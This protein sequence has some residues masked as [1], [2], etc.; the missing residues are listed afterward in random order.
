MEENTKKKD[1]KEKNIKKEIVGFIKTIVIAIICGVIINSTIIASAHVIS[2]SMENTIMTD[3][4]V[5]GLRFIYYFSEP[6]R[7]DIVLFHPPE[8]ADSSYPYVKRIIGLPNEK[9]EIIDG[10][11]F[12]DDSIS[13]LNE[14]YVKGFAYGNFGPFNVPDNGYFVMGDNRNSSTDSRHWN[15]AFIP[16]SSIIAKLYLEFY[17]TPR[18]LNK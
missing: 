11:V 2:G 12:I 4:R 16:R 10:K 8:G 15:N 17:P 3:S 14:G 1:R 7:F 5:M 6:D 9:V 18:N 13:P